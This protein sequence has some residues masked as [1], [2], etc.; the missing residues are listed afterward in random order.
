[1]LKNNLCLL[2]TARKCFFSRPD[3]I[4]K[5]SRKVSRVQSGE[6]V[7]FQ[8]VRLGARVLRAAVGAADFKK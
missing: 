2:V 7:L 5:R 8:T 3:D 6:K 1:V 4:R